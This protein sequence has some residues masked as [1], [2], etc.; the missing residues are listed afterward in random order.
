M[1]RR[2]SPELAHRANLGSA[3]YGHEQTFAK[4]ESERAEAYSKLRDEL[5]ATAKAFEI[6]M[7]LQAPVAYWRAR[8]SQYRRTSRWAVLFLVVF[9]VASVI[10]L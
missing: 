4:A 6:Q 8:A 9:A 1:L 2:T 5:E 3:R 7:E 10:G